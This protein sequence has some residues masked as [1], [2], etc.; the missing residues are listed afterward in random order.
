[1][2]V[3][4]AWVGK[5]LIDA[6]VAAAQGAPPRAYTVPLTWAAIEL[7]LVAG[8]ALVAQAS[9]YTQLVLRSKLG[10]HIN[11]I[12]LEKAAAVSYGKFEDPEFMNRLTQARREASARP[13]DLV[14]QSLALVRHGITLAGFAALLVALGY[15][16]VAVLVVT[17]IPPFLAEARHG[18]ALYLLQRA[19]TQKNRKLFYL[20][21]VL[22]T[23][24]TVKEVKLFSLGRWL[25]ALYRDVQIGFHGEETALARRRGIESFLLGLFAMVALYV[26]YG[27]IVMQTVAGVL[28]IGGMTLY[29]GVFRQGQQTMQ[30]ALSAIARAYEDNLFMTN[31]FEYLGVP[32]DEP[33][34]EAF[35]EGSTALDKAPRVEFDHVGFRYPDADRDAL[36]DVTMVIEPGETIALVGRNGAGTTT[37]I[38]LL[39]GLYRPT[40]GRILIDGADVAEMSAAELRGK[41]GVIFQDF[42]RFQFSAGDNV[43]VGWLPALGDTPAIEK[44]I[45]AAGAEEVIQRLPQGLETPL[46]RA[47]G[48]DDLSVGQWQRIALARA[49]MR[50]SRL[51]ILDEPTAAMDAE[52]EHEIFQRFRDLKANRTALLITHRFSTARMADRIVVFEGGRVVELGTHA[53]L[54][55]NN[56]RYAKMFR[57]QAE[58]YDLQ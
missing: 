14:Q 2:L 38:K 55:A 31:L 42:A 8:R 10:L 57:L 41:I 37:L 29:I 54:M 34:P 53:T 32:E 40:S 17:A 43:G 12:I 1:G 25:I 3:G 5:R 7:G 51:L 33:E 18:Q 15:W 45:D 35:P 49:F 19:R 24:Q 50:K 39:V 44:A 28:T 36:S 9:G 13:L 46:G 21:S 4:I 26:T 11:L 58:G 16:A 22:T 23:E 20:E 56:E 52:A 27:F 6:V 30:S 47:F 48:G